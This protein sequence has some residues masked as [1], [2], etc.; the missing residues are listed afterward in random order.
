VST[1]LN[2]DIA[3]DIV[4]MTWCDRNHFRFRSFFM[5]LELVEPEFSNLVNAYIGLQQQ[6]LKTLH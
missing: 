4:P 5:S 3:N 2:G 1:L 6:V